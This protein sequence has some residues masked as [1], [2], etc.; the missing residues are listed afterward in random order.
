MTDANLLH[1]AI[2]FSINIATLVVVWL[3]YVRSY[4]IDAVRQELFEL[5]DQMFELAASE[6]LLFET[7][8]YQMLEESLNRTI[9]FAWR[10]GSV[11]YL[12]AFVMH[13][14]YHPM[15][16]K[17]HL[18][19]NAALDQ[20]PTTSHR[21]EFEG[22]RGAM[23]RSLGRH[24]LLSSPVAA[25]LTVPFFLRELMKS[26]KPN[27][28]ISSVQNLPEMEMQNF[29]AEELEKLYSGDHGHLAH[30]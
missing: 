2:T 6:P 30:Q 21:R 27:S 13:S 10:F 20:L 28:I 11:N 15:A 24:L 14:R 16:Q 18:D 3:H 19:W 1:S 23:A 9:Q 22:I 17:H 25:V 7:R 4:R 26:K 5:R 12:I 8:A 29:T